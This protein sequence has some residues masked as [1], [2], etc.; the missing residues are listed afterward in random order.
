[1]SKIAFVNT[2][3]VPSGEASVNRMLSLAKGL[4]ENGNTVD[5]LSSAVHSKEN[6]RCN[7][8]DVQI[9][10]FGESSSFYGLML[11]LKRIAK[12]IHKGK[13]DYV[14]AITSSSILIWSLF[15][16]CKA[17]H[18]K[19]ARDLSEFPFPMMKTGLINKIHTKLLT[20]TIYKLF[21]AVFIM[22]NPLIKFY[23]PLLKK[24][25]RVI[26]LPMTVDTDRFNI[27]KQEN[28]KFGRYVAYCGNMSG[29]KD[30][31]ENLIH[32][33]GLI[34]HEMVDVS[35]VLIGGTNT[36]ERYEELKAMVKD[37]GY[38]N[39]IFYGRASR[40]EMP[41]LLKNAEVLALARPS[42]LQALGGFP[43]K[44]GEYLSTGNPVV[45]TAV[46]DIPTYLTE[47]NSYIVEPDNNQKFSDALKMALS[48]SKEAHN[49]G[50]KGRELALKVF[51]F[52]VQSK[53]LSAFLA[54]DEDTVGMR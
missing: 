43:T 41:Q 13:Y 17:I 46:G 18:S 14:V 2:L 32:S 30:G 1:M 35:L 8:S 24:K 20:H 26:H 25:C 47:E 51:D 53:R 39:I 34:S 28:T 27:P 49:R 44:L 16:I 31:V 7:L 11:S 19:F 6:K 50:E 33:F 5:I 38:K 40:D 36:P 9:F 37:Y 10:N 42:S 48:D 12:Q 4:V 54:P 45:I 21:D 3:K 22:T 23:T 52:R 29:N 15:F